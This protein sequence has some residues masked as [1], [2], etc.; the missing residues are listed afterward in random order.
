MTSDPLELPG[1]LENKPRN[2]QPNRPPKRVFFAAVITIFVLTFSAADSVGFVP[3]Y[4]DGS[5]EG[6][7]LSDLPQLGEET[8]AVIAG[9]LP[10]RIAVPAVGMDLPIQ[11]PQT[12]DIP[13]LDELLKKGPI[14]YM[15]SAKLGEH[16]NMLVFAHSSELP[17]VRNQMYKAFNAV[18]ELEVGDTISLFGGGKEYLYNVT[19]VRRGDSSDEIV[20]LA[21]TVGTKLTLVTC[22][23]LSSKKSTRWIAEAE[24][25]GAI[26][27]GQ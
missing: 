5:S 10:E 12:R 27:G 26:D 11:N 9:V 24:F 3:S 23:T 2:D 21:H 19:S 22:D 1:E 6:V 4:I 13:V 17:V 8:P 18:A 25:I 14:R 15:D 16:G 20:D 7:A